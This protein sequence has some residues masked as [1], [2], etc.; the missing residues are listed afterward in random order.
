MGLINTS[1]S[2]MTQ[3]VL[4]LQS[5][6]V[7]NPFYLFNDKKGTPVDY[8]NTNT[9]KST[10]DPAL[11]LHYSDYGD[12]SPIRYNLIKDLYIY[13]IDR[14]AMNLESGEYGMTSNEITGDATILPDTITP[15]PGDYFVINMTKQRYLFNVTSVSTDTF[16]NGG[17][18][19]RIEYRLKYLS[20]EDFKPLVEDEF[21]FVSGN[22]GTNY[23]P[24]LLKSKF[25]MLKI[26]D[27]AA[28]NLKALFRGLYFNDKVQTYTF[29]H[30]YHLN[31]LSMHANHFYDPYLMEF[32]IRHELLK[33]AT[34]TYDFIDHKTY[35]RPEF[36]I[37]YN[38]SIWK[39]LETNEKDELPSCKHASSATY[40]DDPGTIFGT[41]YELYFEMTYAIPDAVA[42]IYAPA[43][44]IIPPE[45][46][47][48]ILENQPFDFDSRYGKY[49]LLVKYFNHNFD[50]KPEDIVP[51]E[52]IQE[53]EN[54][55][56]NYFLLPMA[57]Y[58]IEKYIKESMT[59]RQV[60]ERL[61]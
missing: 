14:I 28:V 52:R 36:N 38:H 22:V 4:D 26:L 17:N 45:V 55:S 9:S 58:I 42:E 32:I 61:R 47:G 15:Y 41:R 49:N 57:I 35:L 44:D 31:E 39:V 6:L 23:S 59:R 1:H 11:K 40:I 16:D 33:D 8:Y 48:H 60:N 24:V 21:N 30:L 25:D 54:N 46:I 12:D 34:G 2:T 37:K 43:I 10:L 7:K 19:W 5:D 27:D 29:V 18:Y 50:Y 20:D 13:G 53:G 56:E 3:S 51:Y